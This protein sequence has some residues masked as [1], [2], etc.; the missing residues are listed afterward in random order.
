M[1]GLP[2]P[3]AEHNF[4]QGHVLPPGSS[5]RPN[6][7]FDCFSAADGLSFSL[8]TSILQDER[9]FMWFGTRYGLD[10]CDGSNF[11]V[12]FPVPSGDVMG[13]NFII[14]LHQ[15]RAGDL[16]MITSIDVVRRD[17]K[18]GAFVHYDRNS[19][20]PGRINTISEDS[21]GTIWI[22]TNG[23]LNRYD[24]SSGTFARVLQDEAVL[25]ITPDRQG[26]L[27]LGTASGVWYTIPG[28]FKQQSRVQYRHDP[29]DPASLSDDIVIAIHEDAQGALWVGTQY[30]GSTGWIAFWTSRT[31]T[32][33]PSGR[34]THYLHNPD[35]P[36]SLSDDKVYA[37]L[38]DSSGRLW[39]G[40]QNGLDLLDRSMG[41]F[42]R[43]HFDR[44]DPHSLSNNVVNDLYQ[45]RGG[46][47]IAT[48]AGVCKLNET[49]SAFTFYQQGPQPLIGTNPSQSHPEAESQPGS[50]S[51]LSD[52]L[53]GLVY[54]D[55]HGIL[56]I[57]TVQGGLNRLDHVKKK[58]HT[59]RVTVYRYNPDD[60]NSI[61][62][63]EVG[64]HL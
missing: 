4:I 54:Q 7:R 11:E 32:E 33:P 26:G 27:W 52:N 25:S 39:I 22:G 21:A 51:V 9:G 48:L 17:S 34:F 44:A 12:Y 18:T 59:G 40:T 30:G 38:E 10:K 60:P 3:V 8:T 47:L 57:S 16:W 56:W 62:W 45:D 50:T 2:A 24:P 5:S 15:D 49:A 43:Y 19:L 20:T 64:C 23:G 46:M 63:G 36:Y 1:T 42:Y 13:G 14:D 53:I 37:V 6:L 55:S 31:A 58:K 41:R 61:S 29:A 28:P 35:D